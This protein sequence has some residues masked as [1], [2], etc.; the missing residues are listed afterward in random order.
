MSDAAQLADFYPP[1]ALPSAKPLPLLPFLAQFIRNPL[2]SLP[3]AVYQEPVVT[4]GRKR[5]LV[6]WVTDPEL[7]EDILLKNAERFPKTRLDRRVLKPI[8]GDGLLTA[9]GENWRWQRKLASPLFRHTE[10]LRYVPIM[11]DAAEERAAAWAG[12]GPAALTDVEEAMTETTFSVIA[13]TILAGINEAEGAEIKRAGREY[14]DPITWEVAASLLR[15]PESLWH[16][17]KRRMHTAA[18]RSREIVHN[19]LNQR[20]A[21]GVNGDDLVARMIS[22]RDPDTGNPMPDERIIDNLSTFLLAGHETTAK[23]L[24][25]TFYI[26]ARA[27][28]WQERLREEVRLAIKSERLGAGSISRLPLTQRVLKETMRLYPPVPVMTRVSTEDTVIGGKPLPGPTLIVIPIFAVHRHRL[29]WSD[30]DRFD[31]DRFLPENE[32]KYP[33]TQFMPFGFGPRVCIGSSFA[34][35][36]ATV[37][38]ATLLQS[39]RF[40]WDGRHTPEP[41]SR[42][43]LRPKGGMP[44]I[45]RPL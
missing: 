34:M 28:E 4:Y 41:V 15:L 38:L 31:P 21:E 30:P 44:L 33:R 29:L 10:L 23:A 24:T 1:T 37:I 36:E 20:R 42:V 6:A 8:V 16:P 26:L 32:S 27:P 7:I 22:A 18:A 35:I 11:V 39:V 12:H 2:R 5:P 9:E 40:E 13:R 17:G 19:L 25:W 3:Q 45:V 43:T 14:L